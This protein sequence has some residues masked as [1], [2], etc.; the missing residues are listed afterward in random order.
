[1]VISYQCNLFMEEKPQ[2]VFGELVFLNRFHLLPIPNITVMT[3]KRKK[4]WKKSFTFPYV[5]KKRERLGM[6]KDQAALW[7]MNFFK[8]H[9]TSPVLKVLSNNNILLQFVSA[10]FIYL[11]QPLDIE[12]GPNR[13]VKR[14]IKRNLTDW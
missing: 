7:V 5:K 2:K 12:R 9:M 11:F 13:F 4:S 3:N 14:L 8:G 6:E 1:M 10:N